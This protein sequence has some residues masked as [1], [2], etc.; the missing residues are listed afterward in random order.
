M[1]IS[2]FVHDLAANPIGR[3]HPIL[4]A[5]QRLGHEIEVLGFLISGP[6]VYLPY[7]DKYRYITLRS[8]GSAPDVFKQSASLADRASGELIYAGKPLLTSFLPALIAAKTRT[9]KPLFL[10]VED[11]DVWAPDGSDGLR[12]FINFYLRGFRAA[13]SAKYGVLLHPFLRFADAVTVSSRKLQRR[14][15]GTIVQHGPD[16]NVFNP[17]LPELNR[18]R[19]REHFG[20]KTENLTI[21]F[22]G[23]PHRHKGFDKLLAGLARTEYPYQLLLCGDPQHPLFRQAEEMFGSRCTFTGFLPN[24]EM[25]RLLAA[26]DIVPIL[27]S[28]GRYSEAQL[29]AKLLEAMAMGKWIIGTRVGDIPLL[30]GEESGEKRGWVVNPDDAID[31]SRA[32][33]E[34]TSMAPE[35]LAEIS[36]K[37]RKYFLE[38]ASVEANT[39]KMSAMLA[40]AGARP[41]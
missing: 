16:E 6:E 12:G 9:R 8:T 10:D 13:T 11:D 22:A 31:F 41:Q 32:L 37:T 15:G 34:L 25:T 14:Y 23:T 20:L 7:R 33:G 17:D 29:P 27:Q 1:K 21:V 5:L 18:Q 24:Q 19:C 35:D 39:A 36:R 28:S 26:G 38:N 30:L 40:S 3:L 4:A 2:V